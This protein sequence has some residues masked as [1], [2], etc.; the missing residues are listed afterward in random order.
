MVTTLGRAVGAILALTALGGGMVA[1]SAEARSAHLIKHGWDIPTASFFAANHSKM[2]TMPFDGVVVAMDNNLSSEVQSQN[3]IS[4]EDFWSSLS[5]LTA[6]DT[7]NLN[8]NFVMIYS[9]PAGDLFDDWSVPL[10]NYQHAARAASEVGLVGI[11]FDIEEYFGDSLQYPDNAKER[12]AQEAHQQ[13]YLRGKQVME[14]ITSVWPTAKILVTHGPYLAEDRTAEYFN[15]N[16]VDWTFS[17]NNHKLQGYFSVGL[18]AGTVGTEAQFIDGGE[19]YS[20]RDSAHF[21]EISY[22]QKEGMAKESSLIPENLRSKWPDII[23]SS[24]GVYDRRDPE[25][26]R[27]MNPDIWTDTL[28]HALARADD[29]VWAYTESHNWWGGTYPEQKVPEAWVDAT[30][31]VRPQ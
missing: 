7:D 11:F 27:D 16:G 10:D 5:P 24:F 17:P 23:S 3:A 28:S 29:Y 4:Y 6:T 9:T 30:W 19:V 31:K 21:E 2:D 18:A 1:C 26:L 25:S 22:W 14:R 8:H 20:A 12:T 13:A 15:A